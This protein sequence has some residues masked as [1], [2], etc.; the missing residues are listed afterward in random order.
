MH[1][2]VG[3]F[4]QIILVATVAIGY[5]L[6]QDADSEMHVTQIVAED[7]ASH[8]EGPSASIFCQEAHAAHLKYPYLHLYQVNPRALEKNLAELMQKSDEVVLGAFPI[9]S[10]FALSP[11]DDDAVTYSDVRVLRTW[12]GSYKPGDVLTFASPSGYVKC[13]PELNDQAGTFTGR[14]DM[15]GP[16]H[17]YGEDGPEVLFLRREN[18]RLIDGSL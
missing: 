5:G 15:T 8:P 11:S 17:K 3:A 6:A 1:R 2:P 16:S 18:S 10:K 12:K 7:Q 14:D 4:A 9:R 13:G